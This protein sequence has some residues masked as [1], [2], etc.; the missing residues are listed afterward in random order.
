MRTMSASAG[1]D[2]LVHVRMTRGRNLLVD[3]GLRVEFT[4]AFG[5]CDE[6]GTDARQCQ[7]TSQ[8]NTL[9]GCQ[10]QRYLHSNEHW[11]TCY[12][13]LTRNA[14]C[15]R[16]SW[17]KVVAA[18]ISYADVSGANCHMITNESYILS[19]EATINRN[20]HYITSNELKCSPLSSVIYKAYTITK[21]KIWSP[22]KKKLYR[23]K[24]TL[25]G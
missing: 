24:I 4:L 21:I 19:L 23:L 22:L 8:L 15:I 5:G 20:V 2:S 6:Q 10:V 11:F 3:E 12:S 25:T 16:Q 7:L 9:L 14:I 18:R 1:W 13:R 17:I